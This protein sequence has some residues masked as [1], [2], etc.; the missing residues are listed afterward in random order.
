MKIIQR[1][2]P[3]FNDR[4][5]GKPLDMIIIHYTDMEG[6]EDALEKLCSPE[7]KVSAHYL[8]SK[9]GDIYQMVNDS[10]RA[11]HAGVS[12]WD[13]ET[14][15]NSRSIGIELDYPGHTNGL[16]P[17]PDEQIHSLIALCKTLQEKY[18]IPT[19]RI[20]GHEDVAPGRK[21]DPGP[22][23]PWDKIK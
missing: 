12:Q 5:P 9:E 4:A 20:L 10:Q 21:Q 11:W 1:P 23:F 8:I 16:C 13:G 14:D 17:Y 22:Y 7:S 3:N 18:I 6:A 15:I 19:N 2:S